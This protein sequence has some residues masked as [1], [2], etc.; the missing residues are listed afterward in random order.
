M[1]DDICSLISFSLSDLDGEALAPYQPLIEQGLAGPIAQVR[2]VA[3]EQAR[4]LPL[5]QLSPSIWTTVGFDEL[6]V[7]ERA[8]KLL[9]QYAQNPAISYSVFAPE[10]LRVM[11]ELFDR[12]VPGNPR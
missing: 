11:E 9:E 7:A 1:V 10:C 6:N 3:L 2:V 8:S 5:P 4:K 12:C